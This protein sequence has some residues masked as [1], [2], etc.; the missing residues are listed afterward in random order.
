MENHIR[1]E[2][3]Y[4]VSLKNYGKLLKIAKEFSGN[5]V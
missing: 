2:G 4:E 5:R 1:V 3:K